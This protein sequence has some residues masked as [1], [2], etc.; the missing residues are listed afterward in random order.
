MPK[1]LRT[2]L[3][4]DQYWD[5]DLCNAHPSMLLDLTVRW[6]L[7]CPGLRAYVEGRDACLKGFNNRDVGKTAVLVLINGGKPRSPT[8]PTGWWN[9]FESDVK[10]IHRYVAQHSFDLFKKYFDHAKEKNV[11]GSVMAC[12]LDDYEN[13]VLME[14]LKFLESRAL[15]HDHVVLVFDGFMLPKK[16]VTVEEEFLE[17]LNQWCRSHVGLPHIKWAVKPMAQGLDL[18][19]F[20]PDLNLAIETKVTKVGSDQEAAMAVLEK[21]DSHLVNCGGTIWAYNK[22]VWSSEESDIK[23]LLTM[24]SI[25]LDIRDLKGAPISWCFGKNE[26]VIKRCLDLIRNMDQYRNDRFVDQVMEQSRGKIY[27]LNGHF[28]LSRADRLD[29]CTP[30][31]QSLDHVAMTFVRIQRLCPNLDQV[32]GSSRLDKALVDTFGSL[33]RLTNWQQ[34][35]ARAMGG[36]YEDKAWV[37]DCGPRNCGKGVLM[38]LVKATFGNYV[39]ETS[40]NNLIMESKHTH[41]DAK[42]YMFLRDL[43]SARIV[44]T[45]E[46]KYG[47]EVKLDGN[48]IKKLASGGDKIE[49]R[50]IYE[51]PVQMTA[52]FRMFMTL[53]DMPDVSPPD[54]LMTMT[55]FDHQSQFIAV[56]EYNRLVSEKSLLAYHKVGDPKIK[57]FMS[58]AEAYDVFFFSTIQC[59]TARAVVN[60]SEIAENTLDARMDQG[61]SEAMMSNDFMADD[62]NGITYDQMKEYWEANIGIKVMTFKK[63]KEEIKMRFPLAKDD[64]HLGPIPKDETRGSQR[65]LKGVVMRVEPPVKSGPSKGKCVI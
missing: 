2:T 6:G 20:K 18:T 13:T 30:I 39:R 11:I 52:Q 51:K 48:L 59:Y 43:M 7:E 26:N 31:L 25:D 36:H 57:G 33:E 44:F 50:G 60:I 53:N 46:L 17:E 42:K 27:F 62:K 21:L 28:D 35:V 58:T 5:L 40:G 56:E 41:E 34:H 8:D 37:V 55:R 1:I 61:D 45:S 63:F 32:V 14:A 3:A 29:R 54:A 16:G 4:R 65:G 23:G 47:P 19:R 15:S 22:G 64:K 9:L 10:A 49:V 12:L 24:T 38:E